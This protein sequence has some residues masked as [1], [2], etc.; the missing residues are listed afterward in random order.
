MGIYTT[1]VLRL[2]FNL[3]NYACKWFYL[4]SLILSLSRRSL[5]H[6]SRAEAAANKTVVNN[7]NK[8]RGSVELGSEC[9]TPIPGQDVGRG[10]ESWSSR[11]QQQVV[12]GEYYSFVAQ[13]PK[14]NRPTVDFYCSGV[15]QDAYVRYLHLSFFGQ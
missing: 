7:V 2:A 1:W 12:A 5:Q 6:L 15:V 8:D 14:V 11:R 3:Q 10:L 4:F 9:H 13:F